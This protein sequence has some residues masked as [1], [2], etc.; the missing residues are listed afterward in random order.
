MQTKSEES[1][2]ELLWQDEDGFERI[3]EYP[4]LEEG[5][6]DLINRIDRTIHDTD[7]A[8]YDGAGSVCMADISG[9]Y[10]YVNVICNVDPEAF[11]GS[12]TGGKCRLSGEVQKD[13]DT[14]E[15]ALSEVSSL[16]SASFADLK[17]LYIVLH[18]SKG[19]SE[20]CEVIMETYQGSEN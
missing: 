6:D 9:E 8:G 7:F 16:L 2:I 20:V 1:R 17:T 19:S 5:L 15:L 3:A 18:L 13:F 14:V 12:L 10:A 11:D 4:S